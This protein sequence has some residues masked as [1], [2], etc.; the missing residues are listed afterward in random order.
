MIAL[1]Q[2][3]QFGTTLLIATD[4]V[5]WNDFEEGPTYQF[6]RWLRL[7]QMVECSAKALLSQQDPSTAGKTP[8]KVDFD[9]LNKELPNV[10]L[11]MDDIVAEMK[12][13]RRDRQSSIP[14]HF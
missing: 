11:S 6:T 7:D 3:N 14:R 5:K 9:N 2:S 10:D 12:A 13:A 1:K 4:Y 8:W